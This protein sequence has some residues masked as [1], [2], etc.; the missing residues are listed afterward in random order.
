MLVVLIVRIVRI[1]RAKRL[2]FI[3]FIER[4]SV[5]GERI[6]FVSTG[7]PEKPPNPGDLRDRPDTSRDRPG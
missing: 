5:R 2:A 1:R 3:T 6:R 4:A 7:G